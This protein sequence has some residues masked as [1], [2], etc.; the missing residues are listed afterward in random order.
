MLKHVLFKKTVNGNIE[1][2]GT[3]HRILFHGVAKLFLDDKTVME[4]PKRATVG[5]VVQNRWFK[6]GQQV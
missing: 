5:F 3:T 6:K 4:S 1:F 2:V